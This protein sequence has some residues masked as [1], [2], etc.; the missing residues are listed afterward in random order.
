MTKQG[1]GNFSR[2]IQNGFSKRYICRVSPLYLRIISEYLPL[3]TGLAVAALHRGNTIDI[4]SE[5]KWLHCALKRSRE[6]KDRKFLEVLS[7]LDSYI[8][9][10]LLLGQLKYTQLVREAAAK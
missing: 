5:P 10:D 6:H 3:R 1:L 7:G 8:S 4:A 9:S 2:S